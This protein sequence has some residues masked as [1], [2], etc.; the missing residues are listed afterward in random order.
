MKVHLLGKSVLIK[1][2]LLEKQTQSGIFL[3]EVKQDL[4]TGI[5]THIGSDLLDIN[6]SPL[7][8]RVKFKEAFS[9]TLEIDGEELLFFRELEPSIYFYIIDEKDKE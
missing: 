1:R 6:F 9:E 8:H 5:I 7:G 4:D 2:D 3:G